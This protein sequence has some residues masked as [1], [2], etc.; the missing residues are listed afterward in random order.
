MDNSSRNS[1]DSMTVIAEQKE[2]KV[3]IANRTESKNSQTRKTLGGGGTRDDLKTLLLKRGISH[4][5]TIMLIAGTFF[6]FGW[7]APESAHAAMGDIVAASALQTGD[8]IYYGN[9]PQTDLGTGEPVTGTSGVDWVKEGSKYFKIEPIAWRV[10]ENASGK[11]FLLSEKAIDAKAYNRDYESIT[12]ETCTARSWLNGYAASENKDNENYSVAGTNFI[13]NAFSA[14]EQAKIPST[15]IDNPN[16]ISYGTA[17]GNAT[18][19]KIFY[20]KEADT[21]NASYGFTDNNSRIALATEYAIAMGAYEYSGNANWW[22]RSPGPTSSNAA[23]V[24]NVGSLNYRSVDSADIAVRPAFYLSNLSD[25]IFKETAT[26]VYNTYLDLK[27][28]TAAGANTSALSPTFNTGITEYNVTVPNAT[29]SITLGATAD[30]LNTTSA[31][32]EIDGTGSKKL[33]VGENEFSIELLD[34][35]EDVLKTYTVTV[36]R[37][38]D[39]TALKS[40]IDIASNVKNANKTQDY[41]DSDDFTAMLNALATGENVYANTEL[42]SEADVAAKAI[43]DALAVLGYGKVVDYGFENGDSNYKKGSAAGL[44]HRTEKDLGLHNAVVKVDGK[45]ITDGA[46]Y[47]AVHGSTVVQ[48]KTAYLDT[49]ANGKHKLVVEFV[50]GKNSESEFTILAADSYVDDDSDDDDDDDDDDDSDAV[51]EDENNDSGDSNDSGITSQ[52]KTG[53]AAMLIWLAAM[54]MSAAVLMLF[55]LIR[56]RRKARME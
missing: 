15:D 34:S 46:D 24:V 8:I 27:T 20:L 40:A 4:A 28:L 3:K 43:T 10:L 30:S 52:P 36:T 41:T 48:L 6:G 35:D 2:R 47:T 33:S 50:D 5:L 25:F 51:S 49:L 9:Y 21:N 17:G 31:Q 1:N 55:V 29:D 44:K 37:A 26:G 13:G 23:D 38:P 14:A 22:L 54:L 18:T 16:S 53:D 11:L 42:Q 45:R 32:T 56:I 19:D 7:S 12:W 39:K